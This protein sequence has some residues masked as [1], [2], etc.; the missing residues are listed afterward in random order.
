MAPAGSAIAVQ[1]SMARFVDRRLYLRRG[2]PGGRLRCRSTREESA[3]FT[4][5]FSP[6]AS[7]AAFAAAAFASDAAPFKGLDSSLAV[8]NTMMAPIAA[9]ATS[10]T[11]VKKDLLHRRLS[12]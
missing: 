10:P 5:P 12:F 6:A 3:S 9:T 4:L 1:S 11:S 8:A 7:I 2:E